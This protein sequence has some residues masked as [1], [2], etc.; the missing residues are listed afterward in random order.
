MQPLHT[1][2]AATSGNSQ[3]RHPSGSLKLPSLP[4]FHPAN[5]PSQHSSAANTPNAGSNSPQPPVS[6]KQQQR[7]YS[8]AQKQLYLFQRE[9][10]AVNAGLAAIRDKPISPR[11]V[12][13]GSPGPVTPLELE[14]QEGY[15]MAGVHSAGHG[16]IHARSKDLVE[17]LIEQEA[18]RNR[19]MDNSSPS[20]P[21][22]A[23]P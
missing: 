4:R 20:S 16:D 9:T 15:L 21:V 23:R 7:L 1:R 8:E 13:L 2:S 3:R 10:I 12:P 6:P 18:R 22:F 14:G 17:K 11:L 5:F 19:D